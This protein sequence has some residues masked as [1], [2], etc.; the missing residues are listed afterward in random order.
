MD[1]RTGQPVDPEHIGVA[2]IGHL[3]FGGATFEDQLG[4]PGA[5]RVSGGV[6]VN[7]VPGNRVLKRDLLGCVGEVFL[8][9]TVIS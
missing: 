3:V 2:A 8:V 5:P 9:T 4:E 6:G 7:L 1:F